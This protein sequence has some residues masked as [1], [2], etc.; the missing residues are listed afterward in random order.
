MTL[1]T[2]AGGNGG[3]AHSAEERRGPTGV[4]VWVEQ[5]GCGVGWLWGG[6]G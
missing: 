5:A 2:Q 3:S 1:A 4:P 6:T